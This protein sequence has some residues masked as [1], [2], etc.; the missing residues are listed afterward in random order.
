MIVLNPP[1]DERLKVAGVGAF[2]RRIGRALAGRWRGYT[3]W[4]LAGNVAA[5][6][7]FDLTP[8]ASL[9]LRNGPIDCR[10][11]KFELDGRGEPAGEFTSSR[12]LGRSAR[13]RG[14]LV[15]G[16]GGTQPL[17]AD[18][19]ALGPLGAPARYCLLPNL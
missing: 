19:K 3:A 6:D 1:Y 2:Y 9:P 12:V 7:Q 18:G 16:R 13:R 15:A 5:A 8:V 17:D 11:L 4:V 10:L 14:P